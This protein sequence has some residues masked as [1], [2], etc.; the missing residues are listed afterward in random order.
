MIQFEW[1]VFDHKY[2]NY[3]KHQMLQVLA[4]VKQPPVGAVVQTAECAVRKKGTM[5]DLYF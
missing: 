1:L 2:S 4:P 5:A 3:W